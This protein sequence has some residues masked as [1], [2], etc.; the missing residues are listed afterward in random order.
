VR[1]LDLLTRRQSRRRN[2]LRVSPLTRCIPALY[3]LGTAAADAMTAA[4]ESAA[5]SASGFLVMDD[6]EM[7]FLS[8]LLLP[9]DDARRSIAGAR[10][11][12]AHA[13]EHDGDGDDSDAGSTASQ[14]PGTSSSD[15]G[16]SVPKASPASKPKPRNRNPEERR[17][18]RRAQVAVSARRHRSRKKAS[19]VRS[20]V[21]MLCLH[22]VTSLTDDCRASCWSCARPRTS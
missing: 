15:G 19:L 5:S 6:L 22:C 17:A 16:S 18:R 14:E 12:D 4:V 7:G 8:E 9:E 20:R 11:R 13:E 21:P 2:D 10:K 1:R 3:L